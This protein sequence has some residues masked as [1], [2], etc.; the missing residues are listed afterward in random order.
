M[1][2]MSSGEL[3]TAPMDH[4][5]FKKRVGFTPL[6][7]DLAAFNAGLIGF[8]MILVPGDRAE[9]VNSYLEK[10]IKASD[11]TMSSS[12]VVFT[13]PAP[14]E[15]ASTRVEQSASN[16]SRT[17]PQQYFQGTP[18]SRAVKGNPAINVASAATSLN[19]GRADEA[20]PERAAEDK[21]SRTQTQDHGR[22]QSSI[23]G[24]GDDRPTGPLIDSYRPSYP[25]REARGSN[26]NANTPPAIPCY[27]ESKPRGC[28]QTMCFMKH[29]IEYFEQEWEQCKTLHPEAAWKALRKSEPAESHHRSVQH[30]GP[31]GRW[32]LQDSCKFTDCKFSLRATEVLVQL[33]NVQ[34][35][36]E[37][38]LQSELERESSPF[39]RK[40]ATRG[41]VR[42]DAVDNVSTA[43]SSD[44]RL[45]SSDVSDMTYKRRLSGIEREASMK[46]RIPGTAFDA[47]VITTVEQA[48][49]AKHARRNRS[50][51]A[52]HVCNKEG[53]RYRWSTG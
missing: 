47:T 8:E 16:A 34:R 9:D 31:C 30:L 36:R 53:K 37:L 1:M 33:E 6:D 35:K 41:E 10:L 25:S 27:A 39:L 5:T 2:T 45:S 3:V 44:A 12:S 43:S 15:G 38:P 22:Y 50:I 14:S 52:L 18:E 7:E 11:S 26:A 46:Q 48:R 51:V 28:H 19:E 42:R 29:E 40:S 20:R 49:E 21:S 24:I 4:R 13:P 17:F 32:A 23:R